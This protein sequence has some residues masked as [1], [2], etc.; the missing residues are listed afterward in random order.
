MNHKLGDEMGNSL[1]SEHGHF[2]QLLCCLLKSRGVSYTHRQTEDFIET[3]IQFNPQF[4]E[5]GTLD[6]D[7]WKQIGE[8]VKRGENIPIHFFSMW[9]SIHYCL[10]PLVD[11]S[12]EAHKSGLPENNKKDNKK[13]KKDNKE[14]EKPPPKTL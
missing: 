10:G 13:D 1:S 5:H 6:P 11:P 7:S 2:L 8:N 9:S 12:K 3:V 4:P 14:E